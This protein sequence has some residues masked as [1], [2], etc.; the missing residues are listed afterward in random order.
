MWAT[1]DLSLV[2][3]HFN[4]Y[5]RQIKHL[6]LL[7]RMHFDPFQPGLAMFTTLHPMYF[8]PVRLTHG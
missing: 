8:H 2:L 6:A 7:D 1:L 3:G 4:P 5:R